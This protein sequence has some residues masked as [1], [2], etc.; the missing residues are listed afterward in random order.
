MIEAAATQ[1]AEFEMWLSVD[2]G[3]NEVYPSSNNLMMEVVWEKMKNTGFKGDKQ[4][5]NNQLYELAMEGARLFRDFS[6]IYLKEA[7]NVTW[8]EQKEVELEAPKYSQ[9]KLPFFVTN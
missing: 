7:L 5:L 4:Q 2:D 3:G 8:D 9:V 1:F 6:V